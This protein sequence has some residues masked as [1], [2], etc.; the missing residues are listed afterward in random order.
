MAKMKISF[1]AKAFYYDAYFGKDKGF[2][3]GIVGYS[4]VTDSEQE[5]IDAV[6]SAIE[7]G[8]CKPEPFVIVKIYGPLQAV[9]K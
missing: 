4:F 9:G 1:V 2:S 8:T 6:A 3:H 7:N 5:L